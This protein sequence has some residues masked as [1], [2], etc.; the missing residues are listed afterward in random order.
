M[1]N[2]TFTGVEFLKVAANETFVVIKSTPDEI[3]TEGYFTKSIDIFKLIGFLKAD[4]DYIH[5]DKLL[6]YYQVVKVPEDA[7]VTKNDFFRSSKFVPGETKKISD[8]AHFILSDKKSCEVTLAAIF[9]DTAYVN[10]IHDIAN[11]K[12]CLKRFPRAIIALNDLSEA[13]GEIE[14]L[15]LRFDPGALKKFKNHSFNICQKSINHFP[16][17]IRFIDPEKVVIDQ[18]CITDITDKKIFMDWFVKYAIDVS[19]AQGRHDGG[20]WGDD[21]IPNASVVSF[22][23]RPFRAVNRW[24]KCDCKSNC[25]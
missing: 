11:L 25:T 19:Y 4:K 13:D 5:R 21:G 1:G 23:H 16:I 14:D 17:S 6:N 15:C 3:I 9:V 8:L 7:V 2:T 24:T 10:F 20:N 12:Y 18:Y 22:G